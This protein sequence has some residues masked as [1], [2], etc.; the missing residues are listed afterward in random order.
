MKARPIRKRGG[1]RGLDGR[2][3]TLVEVLLTLSIFLI[4]TPAIM[5]LFTS[6]TKAFAHDEALNSLKKTN[7][8][9]ASYLYLKLGTSKRIFHNDA[10]G[11]SVLARL[12]MTQ[13]SLPFPVPAMIPAADR[14]L[15]F[16][17]EAGTFD[18]AITGPLPENSFSVT[19]FGNML[20]FLSQDSKITCRG[21][22]NA[23]D[24]GVT[25]SVDMYKL[26][27]FYL[28]PDNPKAPTGYPSY[29][30][31]EWV[32]APMADGKSLKDVFS[33]D[34]TLGGNLIAQLKAPTPR[35]TPQAPITYAVDY[36]AP[37][38]EMFGTLEQLASSV[39]VASPAY[40]NVIHRDYPITVY[41]AGVTFLQ[42][43]ENVQ[44]R[45][46]T[47][48]DQMGMGRVFRCAVAPNNS[49]WR[50][51]AF[52]QANGAFPGGFEVGII[53]PPAARQV[54]VR[55]TNVAQGAGGDVIGRNTQT[56]FCRDVW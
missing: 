15:P 32:S 8:E 21:V 1:R 43:D 10:E 51:P 12:D 33:N 54:L 39:T 44:Y 26:H 13:G 16:I 2:G 41:N 24:I 35:P 7:Q 11:V 52:A 38:S 20:L 6:V 4:I 17:R 36:T 42:K 53:G 14:R 23:V 27:C 5:S 3:M 30:L 37:V 34:V 31:I 19:A 22:T 45:S 50:V 56:I 55:I 48:M 40:E 25:L 29:R 9:L 18:R 46:W 28:T 47:Y 49:D